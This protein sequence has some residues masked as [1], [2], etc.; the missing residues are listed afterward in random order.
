MPA[1]GYVDFIGDRRLSDDKVETIGRWVA[2]GAVEGDAA[3]LPPVPQWTEGWQ[4]GEPDL[5]LTIP[6]P[7]TLPAEG[8]DVYRQFVL[9]T[10]L[11]TTRYIRAVEIRPG[12]PKI[13]HHALI[14]VDRTGYLARQLD[15]EEP[16][17]GFDGMRSREGEL[18]SPDGHFIIWTP[19]MVPD[20]GSS[21]MAWRLDQGTDLVL[22]LHMAPSGKPEL[23]QP[24]VGLYFAE[25]PPTKIPVQLRI[26]PPVIDIPAGER[27]Y[28]IEDSFVLPVDVDVLSIF[29]HAHYLGK[30]MECTAVLPDGT[31]RWLLNIPDWDFDWQDNYRYAEPIYLPQGTTV[32][33]RF[34]YDNSANN[35]RNPN[36]PPRRVVEGPQSTDEMG[37]VSLRILPRNPATA[38]RLKE[39]IWRHRIEQTPGYFFAHYGAGVQCEAQGKLAEAKIHYQNSLRINPKFFKAHLNL[40]NVFYKQRTFDLAAKQYQRV[41]ELNPGDAL[42]H[43]NLGQIFEEK[44]DMSRAAAHFQRAVEND[45]SSFLAHNSLGSILARRGKLAEAAKHFS[46]AIQIKPDNGLAH[47]NLGNVFYLQR[48]FAPASVQYNE[49]LRINPQDAEARRNLGRVRAALDKK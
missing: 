11:A 25:K 2:G 29:P 20:E 24:L 45:S 41:L 13:A 12:N 14:N 9:P 15:R 28:V 8:R 18:E 23:I 39:T 26:E 30:V 27:N 19:G 49:A 46:R 21:D 35:P 40:G 16:G 6:E 17:P 38:G 4:L 44:Q 48:R 47:R 36:S 3:D 31:R 37:N 10:G 22:E 5:V 1:H 34:T 33:M 32:S 7:Y 43:I 42:A